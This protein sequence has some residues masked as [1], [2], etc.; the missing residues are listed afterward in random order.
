MG[1]KCSLQQ[2]MSL[3]ATPARHPHAPHAR[4]S[5]EEFHQ[6]CEAVPERRLELIDGEVLEVI[7]KGT[8]HSAVV[9]RLTRLITLFLAAR[10]DAGVELRVESPLVLGSDS[11]PEPDLALVAF[12]ADADLEAHPTAADT[13]LVIEVA[14]T[15][16]RFDLEAKADLYREAGIEHYWVVD[17]LKP[18][19]IPVLEPVPTE[20][21]LQDL[22]GDVER[23]LAAIPPA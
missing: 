8:R 21:L 14:D 19:M 12:Q 17:V 13:L 7:A 2:R 6:L 10:P 16:L 5:V 11:E 1:C 15:S 9:N 23:L 20:P 18:R 22:R 4:F 3:A